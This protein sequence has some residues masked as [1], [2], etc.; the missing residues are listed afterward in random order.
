MEVDLTQFFVGGTFKHRSFDNLRKVCENFWP[1]IQKD[2]EGK[3]QYIIDTF[4]GALSF[5]SSPGGSSRGMHQHNEEIYIVVDNTLYRV[6]EYGEYTSL[7]TISGGN[8][9]S[10]ASVGTSLIVVSNGTAYEWDGTT[11]TIGSD[12][13]LGSPN[14]VTGINSQA[15][16]DFGSGQTF[17]VSDAGD[18]LNVNALN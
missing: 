15:I 6:S 4:P 1:Q 11:F 5:A 13:D 3:S 16:Y 7:G 12:T 10:F 17:S 18:Y 9:C 2:P 8:R 14:S